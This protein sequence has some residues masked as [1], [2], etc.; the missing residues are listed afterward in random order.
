MARTKQTA[1]KPT[2]TRRR[3]LKRALNERPSPPVVTPAAPAT[4][5]VV[6]Q[7]KKRRLNDAQCSSAT[8]NFGEPPLKT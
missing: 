8:E 4:T 6:Q 1:R 3:G 2:I 7:A 5:D